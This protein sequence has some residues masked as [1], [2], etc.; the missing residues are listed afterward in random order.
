MYVR[1]GLAQ[2]ALGLDIAAARL[3]PGFELGDNWDALARSSLEALFQC[4]AR[5]LG[6]SIDMKD[7]S[8]EF[9]GLESARIA[10]T[11]GLDQ[12]ATRVRVATATLATATLDKVVR[13]RAVAHHTRQFVTL[14]LASM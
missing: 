2:R 5:A 6:L 14:S 8:E 12:L 10:T 11:Q 3:H 7:T 9:E 13:G 1:D 4:F